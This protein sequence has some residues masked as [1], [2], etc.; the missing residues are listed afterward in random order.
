LH[1][2]SMNEARSNARSTQTQRAD[3]EPQVRS[4]DSLSFG[5]AFQGRCAERSFRKPLNTGL[6][7]K[8]P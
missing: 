3:N 1:P 6:Y 4:I 2:E 7:E 8:K 5:A